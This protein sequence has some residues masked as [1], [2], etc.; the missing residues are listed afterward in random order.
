M[1]ESDAEQTR[2]LLDVLYH[3]HLSR[4]DAQQ[5]ALSKRE[6]Q[7]TND[8]QGVIIRII[9]RLCFYQISRTYHSVAKICLVHLEQSLAK[10]IIKLAF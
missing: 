3:R 4:E 7:A 9:R 6:R 10:F 8:I 5:H 1:F 2:T